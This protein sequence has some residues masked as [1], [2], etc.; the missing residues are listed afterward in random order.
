MK[1]I[2]IQC[3]HSPHCHNGFVTTCQVWTANGGIYVLLLLET[4]KCSTRTRQGM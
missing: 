4:T 3:A 1:K 2:E